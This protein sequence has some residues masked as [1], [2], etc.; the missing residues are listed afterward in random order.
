MGANSADPEVFIGSNGSPI[1]GFD[2]TGSKIIFYKSVYS[3]RASKVLKIGIFGS[4]RVTIIR[5]ILGPRGFNWW[6]EHPKGPLK[7]PE[8]LP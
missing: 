2:Q 6:I 1:Y 5:L 3:V 4:K 8:D 7:I